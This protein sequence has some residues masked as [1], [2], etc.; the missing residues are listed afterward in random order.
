MQNL[1]DA[2]NQWA[3]RP[4]DERFWN[5]NEMIA[6]LDG[7]KRTSYEATVRSDTLDVV[8]DGDDVALVGPK[9]K[10]ARMTNY[11]FKQFASLVKAPP[12]YLQTLPT[13]LAVTNL[14]HGLRMREMQ[15]RD[16]MVLGNSN[17]SQMVRSVTSEKY[18]RIWDADIARGLTRLTDQGWHTPPARPHNHTARTR[19]AT[20]DDVTAACNSGLAIKEGDT[21]A[22]AGLYASDHDLFVFMIRDDRPVEFPGCSTPLYRGFFVSNSEVGDR[23]FELCTFLF[24]G[25]CGNHI[26][27]G[28]SNVRRTS[29]VH[30]GKTSDARAMRALATKARDFANAS[31]R[32]DQR[33]IE[34]ARTHILG[35]TTDDVIDFLYEKRISTRTLAEAA[36]NAAVDHQEDHV[37]NPRSAW[38]IAQGFTRVSQESNYADRRVTIDQM[39]TKVLDRAF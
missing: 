34:K 19:I 2:S 4:D 1:Y 12:A 37:S 35:N 10:P 20:A 13:D 32:D 14:R 11:A 27:W 17:G 39:A 18:C 31:E 30:L 25:V 33:R 29:I 5:L 36:V 6:F 23:R 22:P 7:V 21:I 26:V 9:G 38:A 8:T 15:G 24:N 28:A 16:L 3:K